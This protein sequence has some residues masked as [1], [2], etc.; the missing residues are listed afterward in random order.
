MVRILRPKGRALI[1][2]WAK[3]Q[4]LKNKSSYLR[5]NNKNNR[6]PDEESSRGLVDNNLEKNNQIMSNETSSVAL[7]IHTNRTQFEHT[8]ILVPWKLKKPTIEADNNDSESVNSKTFLR[9]YH[10]FEQNE[11]E[12]IC[13]EFKEVSIERSY[14]D[15]GNWCIIF[16]KN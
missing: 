12:N 5:Q 6:K 9:F 11:L 1:Y 3:N 2:V 16:Q 10:V 13:K 4:E 14:Y 15:Q 8:D 7:P